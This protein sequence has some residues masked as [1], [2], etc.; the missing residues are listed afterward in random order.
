MNSVKNAQR[1][2]APDPYRS[3]GLIGCFAATLG[4]AMLAVGMGY[5]FDWRTGVGAGML[6]FFVISLWSLL[7]FMRLDASA[8]VPA[9]W[10]F[11]PAGAGIIIATDV[12]ATGSDLFGPGTFL[13]LSIPCALLG[14][15]G[16]FLAEIL[17]SGRPFVSL[18]KAGVAA[19][20]IA[21]PLPVGGLLGASASLGHRALR[22]RPSQPPA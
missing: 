5:A 8:R 6:L 10:S 17:E 14:G 2:R 9:T 15:A 13:L 7:Q 3:R 21:I 16:V 18:T 20:L 19:L 22:K 4:G 12:L 11:A 1:H